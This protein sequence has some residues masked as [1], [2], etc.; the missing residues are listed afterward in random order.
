MT[1]NRYRTGAGLVFALILSVTLPLAAQAEDG[2]RVRWWGLVTTDAEAASAFY[3]D[4][5]ELKVT[6]RGPGRYVIHREDAM[7]G[8]ITQIEEAAANVK[9]S[10]WIVGFRVPNV[11]VALSKAKGLGATVINDVSRA[12][13]LATWAAVQDP[14][15]AQF[16]MLQPERDLGTPSS[17]GSM[18]WTELWTNDMDAS[19]DFYTDVFGWGHE[20]RN[21]PNGPYPVFTSGEEARAGLVR[22]SGEAMDLGWAPYVGV[23]DLR[24]TLDRAVELGGKIL[25]EPDPDIL[26]GRV[27]ALEDP[28]GCNFLLYRIREAN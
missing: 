6:K 13:G 16:V 20:T 17:E 1:S 9:R 11:A 10:T 5:F 8:S 25:Q 19:V 23:T 18:V 15:G 12:E 26:D 21:H 3:R 7:V 2:V 24:S 22:I 4:L 27:A 28:T 14:G